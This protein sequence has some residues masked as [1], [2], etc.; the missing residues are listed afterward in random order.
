MLAVAAS[1]VSRR[2]SFGDGV[3]IGGSTSKAASP[4]TSGIAEPFDVSTGTPR[5]MASS[6]GMPK[7]SSSDGNA[8]MDARR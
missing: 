8:K 5:A 6:S 2:K 3:D 7:P 4:A 1:P